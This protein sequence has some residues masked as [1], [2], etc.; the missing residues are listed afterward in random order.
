L[1]GERERNPPE[2]IE[3]HVAAQVRKIK[4]EQAIALL[5]CKEKNSAKN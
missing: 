1:W 2:I 3:V 4:R 5:K